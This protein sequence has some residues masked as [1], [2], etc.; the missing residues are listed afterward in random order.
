MRHAFIHIVNHLSF[1]LKY[2]IRMQSLFKV[3]S[4]SAAVTI[5]TKNGPK[6]KSTVVLQET[7]DKFADSYVAS[8]FGNQ[9]QL[10]PGDLVWAVLRFAT[11][12]WNGSIYQEIT[13]QEVIPF[14]QH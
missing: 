12:E 13:L 3:V 4:Q 1:I 7:G 14:T 11:R 9:V 2:F 8:L 5:D 6:Q 10:Y